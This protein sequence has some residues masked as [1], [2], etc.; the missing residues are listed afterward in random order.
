M[1]L[2]FFLTVVGVSNFHYHQPLNKV[3][4]MGNVTMSYNI[5]TLAEARTFIDNVSACRS[6]LSSNDF[7]V[8]TFEDAQSI[9]AMNRLVGMWEDAVLTALPYMA[10]IDCAKS[11]MDKATAVVAM[12]DAMELHMEAI[13]LYCEAMDLFTESTVRSEFYFVVRRNASSLTATT[14]KVSLN[15]PET[16]L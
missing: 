4:V 6:F 3:P 15:S 11:M 14:G 1:L 10:T 2:P 8:K 7:Q 9:L 5:N 13:R 12:S 16:E